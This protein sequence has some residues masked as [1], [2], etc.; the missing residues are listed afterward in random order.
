MQAEEI[1]AHIVEN[2][3]KLDNCEGPHDFRPVVNARKYS[4]HR[5]GGELDVPSYHWYYTGLKHGRQ[6]TRPQG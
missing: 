1:L 6:Q 4:C 3:R 5:C 2:Q